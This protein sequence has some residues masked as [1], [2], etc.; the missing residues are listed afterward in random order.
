MRLDQEA[1]R[2]LDELIDLTSLQ[3]EAAEHRHENTLRVVNQQIN[4][5][6]GENERAVWLLKQH[7]AKHG[8]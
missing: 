1:R 7:R 8:C 5:K 3:R 6:I 2:A 4:V